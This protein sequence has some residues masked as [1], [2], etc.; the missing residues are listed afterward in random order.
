MPLIHNSRFT[1]YE[2]EF[3][4]TNPKTI[5]RNAIPKTNIDKVYV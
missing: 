1:S 4:K 2:L 5:P 3:H